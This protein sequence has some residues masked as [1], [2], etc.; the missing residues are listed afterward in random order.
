MRIVIAADP[1][2]LTALLQPDKRGEIVFGEALRQV[3]AMEAVAERDHAGRRH[4][5]DHLM[6]SLE[7]G[8]RIVGR[9]QHAE[10]G[11]GCALLEMKIRDEKSVLGFPI[12]RAG[13]ERP[14]LVVRDEN[15]RTQRGSTFRHEIKLCVEHVRL[16]PPRMSSSAVS[17]NKVSL[18][19]LGTLSRPISSMTGT[20]SGETW[21]K[22]I[23]LIRPRMR[24]KNRLR[25]PTSMSPV[26]ASAN[27]ARRRMWS[28]S[29]WRSTS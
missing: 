15:V 16:R 5:A 29:C 20:A 8:A 2:P 21:L 26:A 22:A 27:A 14:H 18:A 9:K 11:E 24:C 7:S 28:G 10:R 17:R 6:Q 4:G 23:C 13:G 12:E 3:A 25:R 1:V 19:S